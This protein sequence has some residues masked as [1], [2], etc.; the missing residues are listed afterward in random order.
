M[1]KILVSGCKV[2]LCISLI[3]F[4]AEGSLA[5][6]PSYSCTKVKTGSVEA[7]VCADESLA[8][9]DRRLAGVYV[10]AIASLGEEQSIP[11]RREQRK[12]IRLRDAC[13]KGTE[14]RA[15][16]YKLYSQRIAELQALYRLVPMTGPVRF[17]CEDSA[18]TTLYVT[19]YA[20]DPATIMVE[21]HHQNSLLFLEPDTSGQRYVRQ[22]QS[23]WEH[24]GEAMVSW[25]YDMPEILC[26]TRSPGTPE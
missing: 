17:F 14:S 13:S 26:R 4:H 10:Q 22:S 15:C 18:N 23:F 7:L 25:G 19:Y 9:L 5:A 6:S 2:G 20:T 21:H 12:W 1:G 16:A 24:Q 11:L 8:E 3:A